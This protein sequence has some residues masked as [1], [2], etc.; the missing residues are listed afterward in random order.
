MTAKTGRNWTWRLSSTA[1]VTN[2]LYFHSFVFRWWQIV[3][4]DPTLPKRKPTPHLATPPM[5]STEQAESRA[6]VLTAGLTPPSAAGQDLQSFPP[7]RRRRRRERTMRRR[8]K[9]AM[10]ILNVKRLWRKRRRLTLEQTF[11]FIKSSVADT[12]WSSKQLHLALIW[13]FSPSLHSS[14]LASSQPS[15]SKNAQ[16]RDLFPHKKSLIRSSRSLFIFTSPILPPSHPPSQHTLTN[17]TFTG[18]CV[19]ALKRIWDFQPTVALC[20][21]GEANKRQGEE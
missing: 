16:L 10:Q 5:P 6:Q 2:T 13:L 11:V 8:T 7:W 19:Y 3:H 14:P 12:Q 15:G 21:D 17:Q 1:T 9:L 18:A 20:A 4:K